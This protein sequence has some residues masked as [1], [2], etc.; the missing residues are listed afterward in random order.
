VACEQVEL[1][2]AAHGAKAPYIDAAQLGELAAICHAGDESMR[3]AR[4][5]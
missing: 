5:E 1:L 3:R 2:L 4:R